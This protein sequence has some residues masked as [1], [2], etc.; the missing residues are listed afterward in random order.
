MATVLTPDGRAREVAPANGRTFTLPELQAVVGG[1]IELHP[2]ADGRWV[3][4]NEDGKRLQLPVNDAATALLHG[5][6][7]PFDLVV[8][9]V[10]VCGPKEMR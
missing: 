3:V 8:G 1:F 5:R 9:T 7:S 4:L 2:L 10:L 6:L